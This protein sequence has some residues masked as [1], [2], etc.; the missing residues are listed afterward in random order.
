VCATKGTITL[1][2]IICSSFIAFAIAFSIEETEINEILMS[3]NVF[4]SVLNQ[5]VQELEIAGYLVWIGEAKQFASLSA[6]V[7]SS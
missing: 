1:V 2:N 7:S 4:E 5:A 3:E 6:E